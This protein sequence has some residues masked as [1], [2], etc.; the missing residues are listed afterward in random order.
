MLLNQCSCTFGWQTSA[1]DDL[2]FCRCSLPYISYKFHDDPVHEAHGSQHAP[3]V[4]FDDTHVILLGIK[5]KEKLKEY[6]RGPGLEIEVH[7][8]D[9]NTSQKINLP[10]IFGSHED[11]D[12]IDKA[13]L[14]T[15]K[16]TEYTIMA[17][18]KQLIKDEIAIT[19]LKS[20]N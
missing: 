14:V 12:L 6:F 17:F 11:D 19:S 1:N 15:S 4:V 2:I 3:K 9:K 10:T 20:L 8:R 18:Y 7:D 5:D 16:Y 13:S